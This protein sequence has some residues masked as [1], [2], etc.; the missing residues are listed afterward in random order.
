MERREARV[1]PSGRPRLDSAEGLGRRPALHPPRPSAGGLP[2]AKAGGNE[3]AAG[4][5]S[6]PRSDGA[7]PFHKTQFT[8]HRR[9]E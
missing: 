4:R 7:W 8:K 2:S 1:R 3:T 9:S 5:R 6:L